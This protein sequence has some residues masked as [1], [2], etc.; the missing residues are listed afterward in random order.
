MP[1]T[2]IRFSPKFLREERRKSLGAGLVGIVLASVCFVAAAIGWRTGAWVPWGRAYSSLVL[3]PW[4][5]ALMGIFILICS[6]WILLKAANRS[7]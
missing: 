1:E 4:V 6:V 7:N 5:V 2:P 3:P